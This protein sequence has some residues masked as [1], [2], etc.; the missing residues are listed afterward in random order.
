MFLKLSGLCLAQESRV[1]S[2]VGFLLLPAPDARKK[3][4]RALYCVA[5]VVAA[6]FSIF[7]F[8]FAFAAKSKRQLPRGYVAD[9]RAERE[10]V[11]VDL[12]WIPKPKERSDLRDRIFNQTLSREFRERYEQRFG[13]TEI[14]RVFLAPNRTS[15]YNDV[16]GVKGTPQEISDERRK[17]GEFMVRR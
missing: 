16:Y 11:S 12:V 9:V 15:Y 1:I 6:C 17:F 3:F 7:A 4:F 8:S 10:V 13:Q 5:S 14:E 2:H